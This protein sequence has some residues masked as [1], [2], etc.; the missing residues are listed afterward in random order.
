MDGDMSGDDAGSRVLRCLRCGVSANPP[1]ASRTLERSDD[2]DGS[3]Q[4]I[5]VPRE[6][7]G[8]HPNIGGVSRVR[9]GV[10]A[11]F[12]RDVQR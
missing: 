8:V 1:N 5:A 3:A 10:P 6:H 7:L 12:R 11:Q 4:G 2:L 9:D